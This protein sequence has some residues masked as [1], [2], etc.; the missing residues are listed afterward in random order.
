M[1]GFIAH[2]IMLWLTPFLGSFINYENETI[3]Y[4]QRIILI[5]LIIDFLIQF[6]KGIII[7][8]IMV[9]N[10]KKI[11][12]EYLKTNALAD[13]IKLLIWGLITYEFSEF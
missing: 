2:L 9:S 3:S 1:L 11:I 5:F 6:N 12:K 8:A 13:F 10:R 7:S 4:I